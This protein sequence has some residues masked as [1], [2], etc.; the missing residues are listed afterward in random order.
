MF[1]RNG[2][3]NI[4]SVGDGEVF[5][6]AYNYGANEDFAT[7]WLL[8]FYGRV[9]ISAITTPAGLFNEPKAGG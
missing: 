2:G 8:Q 6:C 3:A 9:H 4:R 1:T 5:K 7:F